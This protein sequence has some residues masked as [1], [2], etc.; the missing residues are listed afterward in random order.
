MNRLVSTRPPGV[1]YV[2]WWLMNHCSW[3][4]QYC[5]DI[6]R[7]GSVDLID[8]D[9]AI[10][11]VNDIAQ[12]ARSSGYKTEWYLTGGEVTEWALLPQLLESIVGSGGQVGLRTNANCSMDLWNQLMTL[13][14]SINMEFHSEY[15]STAHF[16][17]CL[18]AA[19]RAGVRVTATVSMLPDRWE[20]L[21][22]M[23]ARIERQW[24]DQTIHRRMLFED[25]AVNRQ[26]MQY[27]DSQQLKLKRQSGP[28]LWTDSDGQSEYT[29]YQTLILEGKNQ[30]RTQPC[31][32]GLEQLIID[33]WGRVYRSHCRVGGKIGQLGT[34]I[35]WPTKP[36]SCPRESCGNGFDIMATKG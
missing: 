2:D 12:W 5:A 8:L 31:R 30:F 16:I 29:D 13:L 17:M 18:H 24:P 7:N 6:I 23:I 32:V 1:F 14:T 25:P 26:P 27:T 19:R 11:T 21:E 36:V 9:S 22:D 4:C 10:Y 35:V 28:L 33:A 3:R 20:E 34:A 15:S